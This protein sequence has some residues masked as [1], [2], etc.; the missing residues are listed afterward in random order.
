MVVVV[1]CVFYCFMTTVD[2]MLDFAKHFCEFKTCFFELR[3]GE[4]AGSCRDLSGV[5]ELKAQIGK[6]I[7]QQ[8]VWSKTR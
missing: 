8:P 7:S 6:G 4:T 2:N 1:V 5:F 3:G